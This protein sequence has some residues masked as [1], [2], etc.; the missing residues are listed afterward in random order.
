VAASTHSRQV[1]A[2]V[3]LGD[4]RYFTGTASAYFQYTPVLNRTLILGDD[5]AIRPGMRFAAR[6]C[7]EPGLDPSKVRN[8]LPAVCYVHTF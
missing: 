1:N 7:S 5:A 3:A 4:G 2:E 6:V 8:Y